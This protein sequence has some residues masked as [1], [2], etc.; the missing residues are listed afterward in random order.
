MGFLCVKYLSMRALKGR[1]C[2]R[3][4][5]RPRQRLQAPD[6]SDTPSNPI[7]PRCRALK[8]QV[9]SNPLSRLSLARVETR[10]RG[11]VAARAMEAQ[12]L[13]VDCVQLGDGSDA[14]CAAFRENSAHYGRDSNV[15][16][17]SRRDRRS[18]YCYAVR[19]WCRCRDGRSLCILVVD[20]W[21]TSYR[22]LSHPVHPLLAQYTL[23]ELG[24]PPGLAQAEVVRRRTTA[25]FELES[26]TTN[27]PFTHHWLLTRVAS[28]FYKSRVPKATLRAQGALRCPEGSVTP[29]TAETRVEVHAEL[30][31][32]I[33]LRPGGWVAL[34]QKVWRM[35]MRPTTIHADLFVQVRTSD[36]SSASAEESIAPLRALSWDIECYSPSHS[37]P[38]AENPEDR[39]IA[40]GLCSRTLY[41]EES[42]QEDTVLCLGNPEPPQQEKGELQPRVLGFPTEAAL[43]IAFASCV[44]ESKA[45]FIIGYNTCGFD[46]RYV[47]RRVQILKEEGSLSS[48]QAAAVFRLS[49]L[50]FESCEP[51]ECQIGSSAMGDNIMCFPRTPGR[52]GIDLWFVLRS[53]L[54]LRARATFYIGATTFP[55][56]VIYRFV[57]T[58]K[59]YIIVELVVGR[60]EKGGRERVRAWRHSRV[61]RKEIRHFRRL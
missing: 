19:L 39:I 37:F 14:W 29:Y 1:P 50:Q 25:G 16:E 12:L 27:A 31:E 20:P 22:R 2:R 11:G 6:F 21:S 54:K 7:V 43:L 34:S 44:V 53:R 35:C 58:R 36:L 28:S 42:H 40:I 10:K 3:H 48:A 49:R 57:C 17:I 45:D 24:A 32:T 52:V 59:L 51:Q 18:G 4:A 55:E 56:A 38:Q 30:L 41:G 23:R 26:A 9:P 61:F 8:A 46:W 47:R 13:D 5:T 15:I 33:N 60:R